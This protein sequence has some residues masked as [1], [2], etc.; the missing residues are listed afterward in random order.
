M[1]VKQ[2]R[3]ISLSAEE[4]ESSLIFEARKHL[5]LDDTEAILDYQILDGSSDSQNLE[6]LMVATTKKAF[7]GIINVRLL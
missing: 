6:I 4:L 1:A 7:D 3:S 2:I 5:P